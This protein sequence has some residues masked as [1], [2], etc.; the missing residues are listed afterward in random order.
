MS[1]ETPKSAPVSLSRALKCPDFSLMLSI[2]LDSGQPDQCC[3][4]ILNELEMS[5][6]QHFSQFDQNGPRH[7]HSTVK[8]E[9]KRLR[10]ILHLRLP[11]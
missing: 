5:W 10:I 3:L 4:S 8:L 6:K 7:N 1:E 2:F 9:V 11:F